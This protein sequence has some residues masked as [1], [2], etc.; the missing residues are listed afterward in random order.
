MAKHTR[1]APSTVSVA[2]TAITD[3]L[4]GGKLRIY[5][6]TRPATVSQAVAKQILLA[7]CAFATPAFKPDV[8]GLALALPIGEEKSAKATGKPTWFR[9]VSATGATVLD[10][11]AGSVHDG[12][13][14]FLL[15]LPPTIRRF[16]WA[17]SCGSRN[18]RAGCRRVSK[19]RN[20]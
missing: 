4:S 19:W 1:S 10:G 15:D 3:R 17:R 11:S 14:D 13:A 7:E 2:L 18:S 8:D 6:G 5:D 12:T 20:S 16:A 9:A